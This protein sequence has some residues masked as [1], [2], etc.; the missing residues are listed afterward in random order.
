[1]TVNGIYFKPLQP[2]LS[3][4]LVS[5][6]RQRSSPRI[7]QDSDYDSR[8]SGI[9]L[10][11][12]LTSSTPINVSE[13]RQKCKKRKSGGEIF[14]SVKRSKSLQD[15]EGEVCL[16]SSN[17]ELKPRKIE[18]SELEMEEGDG[19]D[20]S[21]I[22]ID[23]ESD[24]ELGS[25]EDIAAP[26]PAEENQLALVS[27]GDSEAEDS[28]LDDSLGESF[29]SCDESEFDLDDIKALEED[30]SRSDCP[31]KDSVEGIVRER[32]ERGSPGGDYIVGNET[33][34]VPPALCYNPDRESETSSSV[35]RDKISHQKPSPGPRQ[36]GLKKSRKKPLSER[37]I[38]HGGHPLFLEWR[39]EV[40]GES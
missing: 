12:P 27:H 33:V 38:L 4:S 6:S 25:E 10:S 17:V 16:N 28:Y 2:V 11:S 37:R 31:G 35:S 40:R 13:K 7:L 30:M 8:D 26:T 19:D 32:K 1:M 39:Q 18:E 14:S 5:V 29:E 34:E 9:S 36:Q 22:V 21:V 15:L 3:S 24:N 23:G 20:D